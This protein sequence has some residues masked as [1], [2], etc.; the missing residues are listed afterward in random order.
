MRSAVAEVTTEE[1]AIRGRLFTELD[2]LAFALEMEAAQAL[3]ADAAE[4]ERLQ[5][6]RLGVRLAQRLVAGVWAEEVQRRLERWQG[7]Y[8]ARLRAAG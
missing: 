6:Q 3:E 4:A 1:A 8:A 5:A 2:L 7:E